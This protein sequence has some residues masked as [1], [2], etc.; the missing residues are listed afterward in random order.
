[1]VS[2]QTDG[3]A[4]RVRQASYRPARIEVEV[5]VRVAS[6]VGASIATMKDLGP[7]GVFLAM[8]GRHLVGERVGLTFTLPDQEH[9][10]SVAAEVRWV[11]HGG[12]T[13]PGVGVRFIRLPLEATIA[14]QEFRRRHDED[15]TPSWPST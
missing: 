5:P 14:I 15:L 4:V 2:F 13:G 11:Q 12:H 7:G 1:M 9:S 8:D 10:I 3:G 6:D